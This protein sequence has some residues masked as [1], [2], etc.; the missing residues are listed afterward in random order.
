M[1][2][3]RW[4]A[5][6]ACRSAAVAASL[7]HGLIS[8]GVDCNRWAPPWVDLVGGQLPPLDLPW[9][10]LVAAVCPPDCR[11][12]SSPGGGR[13]RAPSWVE[14]AGPATGPVAGSHHTAAAWPPGAEFAGDGGE[15]LAGGEP[16]GQ[17]A[18]RGYGGGPHDALLLHLARRIDAEAA[19]EGQGLGPR[20]WC[21]PAGWL[22]GKE[23]VG[24][25]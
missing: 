22:N 21:S 6:R 16:I 18:N 8:L 12:W 13:L 4:P 2:G 25:C 17:R 20:G 9:V 11:G 1:D 7:P 5:T 23:V 24:K 3:R 15:F 14:L 10:E 19:A